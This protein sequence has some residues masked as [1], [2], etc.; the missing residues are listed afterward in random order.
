[1]A[2][3]LSGAA[4]REEIPRVASLLHAQAVYA[5]HDYEPAALERDLRVQ[6]A[7][8]ERG[9]LLR[10]FKDQVIFEKDQVLTRDGRPF[11]V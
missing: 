1:V 10:T 6:P 3:S 11:S 7:L 8:L 5:N 9:I 4:A 2:G